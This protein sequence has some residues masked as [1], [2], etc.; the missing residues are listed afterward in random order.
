MVFLSLFISEYLPLALMSVYGVFFTLKTKFFQ[1]RKLP[2]SIKSFIGNGASSFGAVCT[3]LASTIG[4]GN[5]VGVATAISIG[6]AGAVFWMIVSSIFGMIIKC[7]EIVLCVL[8]KNEK[9][10]PFGYISKAFGGSKFM[11]FIFGLATLF[12]SFTMGNITQVNTVAFAFAENPK[13]RLI[14]GVLVGFLVYIILSGGAKKVFKFSEIAVPFMSVVYLL[15]C[16]ALL[17]A[18]NDKILSAIRTIF[19]GAFKPSAV[20]GGAVGSV[21]TTVGIGVARGI[22]S[23]EAGMGTA[24]FAHFDTNQNSVKEG[25]CGIFEVFFDTVVMCSITGLAIC[26]SGVNIEFGEIVSSQIINSTFYSVCGD[27]SKVTVAAMLGIF[28]ITSTVGWGYFG[29]SAVGQ[30]LPK[31]KGV[32]VLVYSLICVLGAVISVKYAWGLAAFFNGVM[33]C[34]NMSAVALLSKK[35]IS[36]INLG[37][38]H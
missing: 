34:V 9:N 37:K 20:T 13:I 28:G 14:V 3:T 17:I 1:L 36:E 23:N 22:F 29:I 15:L 4:T 30:I 10:G 19:I 21:L 31:C 25:L 24:A 7:V 6:G 5:I 18:N 38:I 12:S 33:M 11:I 27:F 16:F 32:F 2:Q 8:Y 26:V 35:A